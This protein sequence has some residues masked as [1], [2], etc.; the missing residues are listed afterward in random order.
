MK[1]ARLLILPVWLAG[2]PAVLAAA[3]V[4]PVVPLTSG[5]VFTSTQ[6]LAYVSSAG[7]APVAD[8]ETIYTVKDTRPDAVQFAFYISS[9]TGAMSD[10]LRKVPHEFTRTVRRADLDSAARVTVTFSS[11]DPETLPGQTFAGTSAAVLNALHTQ[12]QIAFVLGVN[13]PNGGLGALAGMSGAVQGSG[14]GGPPA[15]L[16]GFMMSLGVAR[17][18]Y[19]GTLKRVGAGDEPFSVLVNGRRV[20]VPAVHARGE[21]TFTDKTLTPEL[22]WLDEPGNPM[23][24]EWKIGAFYELVTR[25][26]YSGGPGGEAASAGGGGGGGGG[27]AAVAA[28]GLAGKDCRAELSGVYFTTAS[29]VV[30]E[31]SMPA[32]ERFAA[33]MAAHPDWVVTVEGHTDNI[34][35]ADYNMGLSNARANAVREALVTRFRVPAGRLQAKGYGLT[36]PVETNAT[37][38]GR[39]HNRRVEVSRNCR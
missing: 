20:D 26:D 37:E 7:N 1:A 5:L 19:R 2:A 9:G 3:Q 13:E 29:A 23:M 21:M 36:R 6:H 39:A 16:G 8:A 35:S 31:A 32:L 4:A 14:T 28:A 34:G 10:I 25:I 11:D 17:H 30:L 18:Y 12:G 24:L 22:W 33:L 27:G 38:Q 15:M